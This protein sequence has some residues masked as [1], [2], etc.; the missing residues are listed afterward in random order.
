MEHQRQLPADVL[1]IG[2]AIVQP[3]HAED[4]HDMRGIAD[5]EDAAVP[6]VIEAERV[7]GI[8]TPP[9]QLPRFGVA[10]IGKDGADAGPEVFLF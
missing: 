7:G 4:R 1:G 3:A 8:N 10:D 6:V 9:F 2:E 5:E